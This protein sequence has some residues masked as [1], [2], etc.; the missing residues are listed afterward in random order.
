[1]GLL[2]WLKRRSS[3]SDQ[4]LHRWHLAWAEAARR[5]ATNHGTDQIGR[6]QAELD[7]FELPADDLEIEREML[8]ALRDRET[9]AV[10]VR[11]CGLPVVETGHRVVG[12]DRC[13]YSAPAS[14]PDRPGEPS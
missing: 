3:P 8:E 13:H 9:L 11:T 10:I 6:L 4:R 14:M 1:M 2:E 5:A 7:A 12:I